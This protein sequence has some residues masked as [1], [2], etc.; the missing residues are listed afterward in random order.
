VSKISTKEDG[1]PSFQ[2]Y[3]DDWMGSIED[4][5]LC[6]PAAKGVWMDFICMMHK[7]PKK[8]ALLTAKGRQYTVPELAGI[9]TFNDAKLM[10][11]LI[12][13]LADKEV[14]SRLE[15]GTIICRRVFYKA[16]REE[17]IRQKRIDAANK[18]WGK[19]KCKKRKKDN[20]NDMQN[21]APGEEEGKEIGVEKGK[22]LNF[23]LLLEVEF[24]KL[25]ERFGE[26][27]TNGYIER[28]NTYIGKIGVKAANKK[29]SSHYFTILSWA[30][31]DE[32][33]GKSGNNKAGG[34]SAAD[35][36]YAKAARESA[37]ELAEG[38]V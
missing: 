27:A 33:E 36:K 26:E 17:E 34:L 23:V 1:R 37:R 9:C 2:F 12:S 6:S 13:E 32:T 11:D 22:Y 25:V 21:N 28:L 16:E 31:K 24:K 8:G 15:D 38:K 35:G 29:Y 5:R 20:A 19:K 7:S 3:P 10:Q 30:N 4:L 14:F 18:R